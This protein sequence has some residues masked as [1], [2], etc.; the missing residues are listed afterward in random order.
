MLLRNK[1]FLK[2]QNTNK[3]NFFSIKFDEI[4]TKWL[5]FANGPG[6]LGLIPG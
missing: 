1:Q 4:G 5:V 6:D 2:L 3:E